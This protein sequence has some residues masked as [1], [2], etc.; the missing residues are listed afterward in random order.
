MSSCSAF[1]S[2]DFSSFLVALLLI[3]ILRS[4]KH[5]MARSGS[6][7]VLREIQWVPTYRLRPVVSE[8]ILLLHIQRFLRGLVRPYTPWFRPMIKPSYYQRA[9]VRSLIENSLMD[10]FGGHS[11]HLN[12]VTRSEPS[13]YKLPKPTK[14]LGKEDYSRKTRT[15]ACVFDATVQVLFFVAVVSFLV[16]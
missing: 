6:T 2:P 15:H 3:G 16:F 12:M 1:C 4:Y 5:F 10:R 9:F 11:L 13:V 8:N 7:G 14:W